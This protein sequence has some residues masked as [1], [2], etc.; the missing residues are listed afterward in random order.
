MLSISSGGARLTFSYTQKHRVVVVVNKC[1][2]QHLY[3]VFGNLL[4]CSTAAHVHVRT[5]F[6]GVCD[7]LGYRCF[8]SR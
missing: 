7:L 6:D 8:T 5:R 1:K 3:S 2:V 4:Y